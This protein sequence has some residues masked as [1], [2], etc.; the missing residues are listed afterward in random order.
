MTRAGLMGGLS[1]G[2]PRRPRR[3]VHPS[4]RLG[5]VPIDAP[6]VPALA[7]APRRR[8]ALPPGHRRPGT[9]DRP[10][11]AGEHRRVHHGPH[12]LAR[13][14][15][16]RRADPN[17]PDLRRR[18]DLIRCAQLCLH[19]ALAHDHSRAIRPGRPHRFDLRAAGRPLGRQVP[20]LQR[21]GRLRR[22]HRRGG[23]ARAHPGPT[24]GAA[25]T[26]RQPRR[27]ARLVQP[28][29]GP[30]LGSPAPP[31]CR[32][33]RRLRRSPARPPPRPLARRRPRA[34]PR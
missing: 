19:S 3:R 31:P 28:R 9:A 33:L 6:L 15:G 13:H 17:C 24:A 18:R 27:R 20:D 30:P 26:T 7:T 11:E 29:E 23:D 5:E 14:P 12:G 32:R 22:P 2:R 34:G 10:A 25:P 16:P 4:R 8:G 1:Q 21:T